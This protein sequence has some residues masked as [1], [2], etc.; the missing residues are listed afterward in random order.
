MKPIINAEKKF[1]ITEDQLYEITYAIVD[2]MSWKR[3]SVRRI[4][5]VID[6]VRRNPV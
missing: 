1:I 6:Q 3:G 4:Y 5:N 2:L